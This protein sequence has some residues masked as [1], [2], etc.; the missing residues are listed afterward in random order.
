MDYYDFCLAKQ[1]NDAEQKE[2]LPAEQD[3]EQELL[4]CPNQTRVRVATGPL[5]KASR[6]LVGRG[7]L[8]SEGIWQNDMI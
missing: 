8:G 3:L 5:L 2:V 6:S 7:S 4:E 1:K